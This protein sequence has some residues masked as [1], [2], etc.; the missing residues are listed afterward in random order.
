[1]EQE[2]AGSENTI[3]VGLVTPPGALRAGVRALLAGVEGLQ[4]TAE[5]ASIEA[6]DG[7]PAAVDVIVTT[8]GAVRRASSQEGIQAP[9][10]VLV[11]DDAFDLSYL[12]V[13]TPQAWGILPLEADA[14][15]LQ[16]A[17]RAL[18]EG[19]TVSTPLLLKRMLDGYPKSSDG[20]EP[21]EAEAL[22]P[23]EMEV[24]QQLAL[25]LTNKQIALALA[26]SE[27]TVK[28]HISSIYSK[29]GVMN[30]AEAVHSGIRH[31]WIEL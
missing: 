7:L 22:T 2:P 18:H 6:L 17:I 12:L 15:T 29:L 1:M 20:L 3:R 14:G 30:R 27:H 21:G 25:G 24:L 31:G 11:E 13:N 16:A 9:V 19:L 10:L 28:Y 23:R 5:A 4:V 26:I 8:A